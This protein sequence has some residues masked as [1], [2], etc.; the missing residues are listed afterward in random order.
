MNAINTIDP[1]RLAVILG[2]SR[3]TVLKVVS[4]QPGF[5]ESVTGRRRP[6]WLEEAVLEFLRKKSAK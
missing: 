2:I 4:R 6:R 5:P 1:D 3:S